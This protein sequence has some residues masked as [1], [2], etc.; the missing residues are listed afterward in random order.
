MKKI[1]ILTTSILLASIG[2][3]DISGA[4]SVSGSSNTNFFTSN[5][6]YNASIGFMGYTSSLTSWN[7]SM[8]G[9]NVPSNVGYGTYLL[10][11]EA[12]KPCL[13]NNSIGIGTGL[14]FGDGSYNEVQ[15]YAMD[16]YNTTS[17]HQ[18]FGLFPSYFIGRAGVNLFYNKANYLN[19]QYLT[20]TTNPNILMLEAGFGWYV[21]QDLYL[22]FDMGMANFDVQNKA[23]IPENP[24]GYQFKYNLQVQTINTLSIGYSFNFPQA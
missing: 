24:P 20:I 6:Q 13:T 8:Y 22:E 5:I 3:A 18:S 10:R 23:N 1:A 12:L 11:L 15:L 4:S 16:K 7:T 21:Y 14:S 19:S 17:I 2:L 9:V